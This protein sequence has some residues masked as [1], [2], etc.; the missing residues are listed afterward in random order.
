MQAKGT[1]F[2]RGC[3]SGGFD[4]GAA[5]SSENPK[6]WCRSNEDASPE[7]STR[8]HGPSVLNLGHLRGLLQQ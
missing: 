6:S 2:G 3:C 7:Q 1:S 8:L 5:V 4:H